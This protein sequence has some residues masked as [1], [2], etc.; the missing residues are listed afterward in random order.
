MIMQ[1]HKYL[2][3]LKKIHLMTHKKHPL[4]NKSHTRVHT[5]TKTIVCVSRHTSAVTLQSGTTKLNYLIFFQKNIGL[6]VVNVL[7]LHWQKKNR[8]NSDL[9]RHT[10]H[11]V[12]IYEPGS[13]SN[14]VGL[15]VPSCVSDDRFVVKFC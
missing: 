12:K 9:S 1:M 5:H 13:Y 6:H 4:Y 7:G 14:S 2:F 15:I 11:A 3:V 8:V 10:S